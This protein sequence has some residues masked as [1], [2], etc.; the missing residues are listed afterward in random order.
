M[1]P[2]KRLAKELSVEGPS[3]EVGGQGLITVEATI[4][5]TN[6]P[7]ISHPHTSTE[8]HPAAVDARRPEGPTGQPPT[9]AEAFATNT[10][11]ADFPPSSLQQQ[12]HHN[13][14]QHREAEAQDD[15]HQDSEEEI[16]VVIKDE[17]ACLHQEN[18]CIRLMQEHMAR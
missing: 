8:S 6:I 13:Q 17:L 5:S 1:P 7:Q 10:A 15:Q 9:Q 3:Q 2:K 16:E 18:E 4:L 12:P 11:T 14:D